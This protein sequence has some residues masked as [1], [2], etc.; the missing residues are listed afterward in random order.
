MER[1]LSSSGLYYIYVP[2][3]V[4]EIFEFQHQYYSTEILAFLITA[5]RWLS[6]EGKKMSN[7]STSTKD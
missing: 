7:K 3:N 1:G 4:H 6:K 5:F 2:Y